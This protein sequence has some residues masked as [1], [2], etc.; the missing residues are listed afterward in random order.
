MQRT[1]SF[2]FPIYNESG[3]IELL[4]RTI[5]EV[6]RE[7][8]ENLEFV[9][10]NDGSRDD[11][12]ALLRQLAARDPRVVVVDLSR[13]HGHQLAVTAGLDTVTGD[14]VVIMDSDMQDPP[15]VALEL[16]EKWR[17][18]YDVVYA[19]RRTRQDGL[20]K[21]ATASAFYRTLNALSDVD[22]PRD[23]GDFRL[24]SRKALEHIRRYREHDR[25]L[26]GMFAHAGF[27]QVAVQFDR[28]ARHA[29]ETGY[30]LSKMLRLASDG[31]MGF[32]SKPLT[33]ISQTGVAFAIL[34]LLGIIYALV[35]RLFFPDNAVPG[36]TFTI[37]AILL[38]GG[39]QLVMMGIIGSYVGRIYTEVKARP[40]YG[41]QEIY[42]AHGPT[43]GAPSAPKPRA[44]TTPTSDASA[45]QITLPDDLSDSPAIGVDE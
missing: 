37:I 29:G 13:N 2:V 40:L 5:S 9:Y 38:V 23:T 3:N 21:R 35:V 32:S 19:Q 17:E 18:G 42:R 34:A 36:W 15:E 25:F 28:H 12:L 1:I 31:I 7:I 6:T 14:A 26:R 27:R 24:V 16:I 30:P 10:V 22:I 45:P 11:S 8:P 4:H 33:L 41:I 20:F 39:L 43:D 44:D